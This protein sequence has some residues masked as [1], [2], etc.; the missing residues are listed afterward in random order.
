VPLWRAELSRYDRQHAEEAETVTV[1]KALLAGVVD[2]AGLFPPA[3]VDMAVAVQNY[4]AYRARDDSWILGR[5]VLPVG[6]LDDFGTQL[7]M[8]G[9]QVGS[10]WRLSVLLGTDIDG[11]V[12]RVRR[13][14]REHR[15]RACV[16]SLEGKLVTVGAMQRAA[17]AADSAFAIFAEIPS[18]GDVESLIDAAKRLG[19]N[20]KIRTGGVTA[21]VFPPPDVVLRFIRCCVDAGVAFKATAGLHHAVRGEYRLTYDTVAPTGMMFGFLNV[22][23]AA[24]AIAEGRSDAE[25]LALLEERDPAAFTATEATIGC[26]DFKFG[27]EDARALR[28]RLLVSFGSCSFT[29][30]VEE[31]RALVLLP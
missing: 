20:A 8:L 2:Y 7:R 21:D 26:R 10:E 15:G 13:F 28:D 22:M 3:G 27:E 11:D 4:A 14:D 12:D 31:L 18:D 16:D 25:A 5:F 23:L 1:L 17:D 29:E 6:R 24:G 9:D 19:V 30:P